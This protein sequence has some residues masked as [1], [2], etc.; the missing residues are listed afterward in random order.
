MAL[1]LRI[2]G[3]T[4]G[5]S[6]GSIYRLKFEDMNK[7]EIIRHLFRKE[8]RGGLGSV[9]RATLVA[10]VSA[11]PGRGKLGKKFSLG[12]AA[13]T[14]GAGTADAT[15]DNIS[16]RRTTAFSHA[17]ARTQGRVPCSTRDHRRQFQ[18]RQIEDLSVTSSSPEECLH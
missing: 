13:T 2:S 14:A 11:S 6:T 12:T 7:H 5:A 9:K 8:F 4:P 17:P 1:T 18:A 16:K 15:N 3:S 10:K